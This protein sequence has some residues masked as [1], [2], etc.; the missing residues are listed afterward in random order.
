MNKTTSFLIHN[1][2]WMIPLSMVVFLWQHTAPII[3]LL[4][5]AYLGRIILNPAV[6]F[7]DKPKGKIDIKLNVSSDYYQFSISDNGIGIEEKFHEKIF[8]IFHSLNKSKD[9]TGIG[10]S[11]VKK[12]V[13]LHDG[14]IWLDSKPG[15]GTT[16]HFTLKK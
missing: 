8:K 15:I 10:L 16:F 7:I 5:F 2:W 14:K 9:S 3:L 4:I 1:L 6:K 11:I 12:I 13:D